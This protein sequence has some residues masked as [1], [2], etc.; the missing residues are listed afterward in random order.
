MRNQKLHVHFLKKFSVDLMKFSMLRQ[1]VDLLS[2]RF[3][4]VFGW[5]GG[6]FLHK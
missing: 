5:F 4:F 6:F 1:P 3:G 2:G